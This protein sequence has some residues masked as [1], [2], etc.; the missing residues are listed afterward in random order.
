MVGLV[1]TRETIKEIPP[2]AQGFVDAKSLARYLSVSP[3]TVARLHA[4]GAI[5]SYRIGA[6]IV[7]FR[8]AEVE[9]LIQGGV[10]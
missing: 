5:P 2:A 1:M 7:R 3:R 4:E 6:R 9:T 10:K 8:I